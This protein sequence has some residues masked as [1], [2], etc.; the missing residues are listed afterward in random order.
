MLGIFFGGGDGHA[1]LSLFV[2]PSTGVYYKKWENGY[3]LL[4]LELF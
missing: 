1:S 4:I 3:L 2:V